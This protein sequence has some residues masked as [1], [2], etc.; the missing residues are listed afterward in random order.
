MMEVKEALRVR[1]GYVLWSGRKAVHQQRLKALQSRYI[2]EQD[3]VNLLERSFF[4]KWKWD[5]EEKLEKEQMEAETAK[6]EWQKIEALMKTADEKLPELDRQ[7]EECTAFWQAADISIYTG[8]E[9]VLLRWCQQAETC[10][11]LAKEANLCILKLKEAQ[12]YAFIGPEVYEDTLLQLQGQIDYLWAKVE[13]FIKEVS[14]MECVEQGKHNLEFLR[15]RTSEWSGISMRG[16]QLEKI[17]VELK[18]N[19]NLHEMETNLNRLRDQLGEAFEELAEDGEILLRR[20][21][22]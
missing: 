18:V 11:D 19:H 8:E 14:E 20:M 16:N 5:Y 3:D 1:A 4:A 22:R 12:K 9:K 17:G 15:G 6:A 13:V 7:M 2:L 21:N 10:M